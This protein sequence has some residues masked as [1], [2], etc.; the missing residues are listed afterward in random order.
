MCLVEARRGFIDRIHYDD[1]ST[2]RACCGDD[3]RKSVDE[4]LRAEPLSM[5][6]FIESELRKQDRGYSLR[7][8][9]TDASRCLLSRDEMGSNRE[10]ANLLAGGLL[11]KHI[12]AGA[13]TCGVAS[14]AHQPLVELG[15][16]ASESL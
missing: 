16:S 6:A 10:I 7:G 12:S 15:V 1:S 3:C 2:S 5:K 13:L 9:S 14:M 4:Q 11:D 8:A